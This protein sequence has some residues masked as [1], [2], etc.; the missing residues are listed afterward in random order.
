MKP[1]RL[2]ITGWFEE[3]GCGCVSEMARFKKD[4]LGYCGQHGDNRRSVFPSI[5]ADALLSQRKKPRT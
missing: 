4:L 5:Q 3:Y 2:K 1:K